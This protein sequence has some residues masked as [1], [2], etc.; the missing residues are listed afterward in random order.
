MAS[1][2]EYFRQIFRLNLKQIREKNGVTQVELSRLSNFDPTCIGKIERGDVDP[3]LESINRICEALDVTPRDLLLPDPGPSGES[4][5]DETVAELKVHQ[6]ELEMQ[7]EEMRKRERELTEVKDHYVEL[8]NASPVGYFTLDDNGNIRGSNRT[9]C[10][11]F[12]V[13]KGD[14]EGCHVNE[15]L[16]VEDRDDFYR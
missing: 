5:R 4:E 6:V 10:E 13:G 2:I 11:I 12:G 1:E 3:S 9:F 14:L 8:Y 7:T 16:H 15:F